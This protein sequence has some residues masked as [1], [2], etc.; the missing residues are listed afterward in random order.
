MK[1]YTKE[2]TIKRKSLPSKV[3]GGQLSPNHLP[4]PSSEGKH[5][6]I[7]VFKQRRQGTT[8]KLFMVM[9]FNDRNIYQVGLYL[10]DGRGSKINYLL[11]AFRE[12]LKIRP[13]NGWQVNI[14]SKHKL[15]KHL[16][17][18]NVDFSTTQKSQRFQIGMHFVWWYIHYII[19][20]HADRNIVIW[21]PMQCPSIL[22]LLS[23]FLQLFNGV[24]ENRWVFFSI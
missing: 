1:E 23:S 2:E 21:R 7:H 15:I 4:A 20:Q 11:L 22:R 12:L 14:I 10:K 3:T 5:I 16:G 24:I 18:R 19:H 8:K 13:D 6:Y 17:D 9:M